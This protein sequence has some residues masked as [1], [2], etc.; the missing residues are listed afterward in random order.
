MFDVYQQL[1]IKYN[2]ITKLKYLMTLN[3]KNP[4]YD[5]YR[6]VLND[7]LAEVQ[8]IIEFMELKYSSNNYDGK[9]QS[10]KKFTLKE[11]AFYDG[12]NGKPAYVAVNGKV[13]EVTNEATWG[14]ATHFGLVAGKDYSK[15]FNSC[16]ENSSILEKLPLVGELING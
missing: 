10:L 5:I 1:L 8:M 15:E 4:I 6:K 16:H 13:Y 7:K 11:L 12:S 2:E 3:F 9:R 14:G